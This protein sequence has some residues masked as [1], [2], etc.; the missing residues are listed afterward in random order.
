[1]LRS[2][3]RTY[4]CCARTVN[5]RKPSSTPDL[6]PSCVSPVRRWSPLT[7]LA[8]LHVA[9]GTHVWG[10]KPVVMGGALC[11][12]ATVAITL[13]TAHRTLL[14]ASQVTLTPSRSLEIPRDPATLHPCNPCNP[15]TL[16]SELLNPILY[17][18]TNTLNPRSPV[19]TP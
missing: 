3:A 10:C 5:P 6:Q 19:L 1:M 2:A 18:P 11:A 13:A 7:P 9:V 8:L 16:I 12:C 14:A 4:C 17:K 15:K